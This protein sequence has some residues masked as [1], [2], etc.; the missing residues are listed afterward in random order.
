MEREVPG[1][2]PGILPCVGHRKNVTAVELA[3]IRV[4]AQFAVLGRW[5]LLWITIEPVVNNVVIKL[6]APEQTGIRLAHDIRF[7]GGKL[8]GNDSGV[9][10]VRFA[11][12]DCK[13]IDK[14]LAEVFLRREFLAG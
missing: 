11:P 13:N 9:E 2:E 7:G 8:G 10:F 1:C 12:A 3:P 6:F 5:R 14:L 4:A